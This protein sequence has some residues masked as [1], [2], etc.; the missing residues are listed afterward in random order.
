MQGEVVGSGS[1]RRSGAG[2]LAMDRLA[3]E[4]LLAG[5]C[6]QRSV[7]RQIRE[8]PPAAEK[9][10][11]IT[12]P[13][14]P[15]SGSVA[16][17]RP[18][19]R[20]SRTTWRQLRLAI[21]HTISL[22]SAARSAWPRQWP[23]ASLIGCGTYSTNGPWGLRFNIGLEHVDRAMAIYQQALGSA[24]RIILINEDWPWDSDSSKAR[25]E[26]R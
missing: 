13:E 12:M 2:P 5:R 16:H 6:S 25:E 17:F 15:C 7:P 23:L 1:R 11:N 22:R 3:A 21:L 24:D 10:G 9:S 8:W 19:Q 14:G 4:V 20:R 18:S 26:S